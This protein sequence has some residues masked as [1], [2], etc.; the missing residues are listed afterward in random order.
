MTLPLQSTEEQDTQPCLVRVYARPELPQG[1]LKVVK[2]ARVDHSLHSGVGMWTCFSYPSLTVSRRKPAVFRWLLFSCTDAVAGDGL[3][4]LLWHLMLL[5]W[6]TTRSVIQ[7]VEYGTCYS[8][9]WVSKGHL[10]TGK[11]QRRE[12]EILAWTCPWQCLRIISESCFPPCWEVF[13]CVYNMR[14][15]TQQQRALGTELSEQITR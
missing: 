6:I 3:C 4:T 5:R 8:A 13:I 15:G 7:P 11:D 2:Q 14:S 1:R 10:L 9:L 12:E